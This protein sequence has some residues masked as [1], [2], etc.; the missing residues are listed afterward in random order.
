MTVTALSL[1]AGMSVTTAVPASAAEGVLKDS[2][3]DRAE[4]VDWTRLTVKN[5]SSAVRA[6]ITFVNLPARGLK[7]RT[8]GDVFFI[9][10]ATIETYDV[11]EWQH[12]TVSAQ[13]D[14]KG[15]TTTTLTYRDETGTS[16]TECPGVKVRWSA[17][18]GGSVTLTVPRACM[19]T[20]RTVAVS[21]AAGSPVANRLWDSTKK[22]A[23]VAM[24]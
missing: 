14:E 3:G 6:R 4:S 2:R 5:T 11:A 23:I 7:D 13:R 17:G 12:Y 16:R 1:A 15:R 9:A 18:R 21:A 22:K 20:S 19:Q 8:Y 10:S 24:D